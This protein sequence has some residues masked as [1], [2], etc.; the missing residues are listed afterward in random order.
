QFVI[1]KP[2]FSVGVLS[3][4][5]S[6]AF[7]FI[8][9]PDMSLIAEEQ[10]IRRE[11]RNLKGRVDFILL[12]CHGSYRRAAQLGKLFPE[13]SI[14]IAGHTQERFEKIRNRQVIVQAGYEGEYVGF[15]TIHRHG[16]QLAFKNHFIPV[17]SHFTDYIP[18]K[19][20]LDLLQMK[21][22]P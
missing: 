15:L 4:L 17:D 1:K 22:A 18:F 7:D 11:V 13:I 5:D 8:P 12:L 9:L 16:G 19:Q 2:G 3:V 14:I 20:K 10:A 21:H 6:L